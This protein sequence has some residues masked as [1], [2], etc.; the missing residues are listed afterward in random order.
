MNSNAT[1]T[2]LV[3]FALVAT[4]CAG[5]RQLVPMD[6]SYRVDT[7]DGYAQGGRALDPE[8]MREVLESEP[9]ANGYVSRSKV[10]ATTSIVLGA[11][12]GALLGWPLGQALGGEERPLWS[13][14][15]V[16]GGAIAIS[17]PLAL[18]SDQ[19]WSL[20]VD[21]HNRRVDEKG[22]LPPP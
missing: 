3:A 7:R 19:S 20:A 17:I 5:N 2:A 16:G 13:L 8:S 10:L 14:A 21:A 15:A 6:A 12:G 11:V 4:A 18:W 1:R 9:E 22:S